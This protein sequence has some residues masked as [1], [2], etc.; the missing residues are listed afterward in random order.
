MSRSEKRFACVD[1]LRGLACLMVVFQHAY[2]LGG[3]CTWPAFKIGLFTLSFPIFIGRYVGWSGVDLFYCLSGFCLAYPMVTNLQTLPQ[4]KRYF[5]GRARRI[6]PPFWASA[7]LFFGLSYVISH[8]HIAPFDNDA[9]LAFRWPGWKAFVETMALFRH[10]LVMSYWTLC[11]EVRWYFVF[12]LLLLLLRRYEGWGALM[13]AITLTIGVA[14][15]TTTV[16]HIKGPQEAM[17]VSGYLTDMPYY[18]PSFALGMTAAY[19]TAQWKYPRLDFVRKGASVGLMVWSVLLLFF[20]PHFESPFQRDLLWGPFYFFVLLLGLHHSSIRN[21]LE[22]KP[23]VGVGL[24]SYSLYLTQE[25]PI[26][27]IH[28]FLSQYSLSPSLQSYLYYG[29]VPAF[30]VCFAYLFYLLFERPFVNY[31]RK[32]LFWRIHFH[33]MR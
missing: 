16:E 2:E 11:L 20:P 1:G 15:V 18:L 7:I 21:I 24:F 29:L 26:R 3:K 9:P 33:W 32:R 19:I 28:T 30:C 27:L 14:L 22:W 12:P 13:G 25:V 31:G 10:Y 23:L 17:R 6:L 5:V 4:W 8:Y